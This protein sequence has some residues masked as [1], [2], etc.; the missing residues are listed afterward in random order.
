MDSQKDKGNEKGFDNLGV[1]ISDNYLAF[2]YRKTEKLSTALYLVTSHFAEEEPLR[3]EL[4]RR[5]VEL[6][7]DIMSLYQL[8]GPSKTKLPAAVPTSIFE[9]VSLLE[10]AR[11]S[12]M[13]SDANFSL[14]RLEYLKLLEML[15][16]KYNLS[17]A[18]ALALSSDFF[19]I[20][21]EPTKDR[22]EISRDLHAGI[23]Q[24]YDNANR[25]PEPARQ[26]DKGHQSM[27]F[28]KDESAVRQLPSA[29]ST[30]SAFQK[31]TPEDRRQE[32]LKLLRK[33]KELTVK[34]LVAVIPGV[35]DKT[36]QRELSAMADQ[37]I[38][39]K[40]GKKRWSKYY[41]LQ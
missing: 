30:Q 22:S 24:P 6:L 10:I 14:L 15:S 4:R 29:A 1:F 31:K 8:A 41:L 26:S 20:S 27:S 13:L 23:F 39:G 5:A 11:V 38:V 19:R 32:I 16:S 12:S 3:F 35:S 17:S 18:P 34:D 28:K 37:G 7:G 2:I 40:S 9:I 21:D 25:P 36:L 33:K